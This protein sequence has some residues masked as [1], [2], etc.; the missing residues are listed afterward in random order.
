MWVGWPNGGPSTLTSNRRAGNLS[1]C[2]FLRP[3]SVMPTMRSDMQ[4]TVTVAHY[5][6]RWGQGDHI[7]V[8]DAFSVVIAG[9]LTEQCGGTTI[10]AGPGQSVVKPGQAVHRT[11]FDRE[12]IVL[13]LEAPGLFPKEGESVRWRWLACRRMAAG[14]LAAVGLARAGAAG[15][16]IDRL[17]ELVPDADPE[18][19]DGLPPAWLRQAHEEL[20][21]RAHEGVTVAEVATRAGVHPVHLSR[22]YRRHYGMPPSEALQRFRLGRA[23]R[24][25]TVASAPLA[26]AAASGGFSD[27]SHLSRVCRRYLGLTPGAATA[28]AT[29]TPIGVASV[30]SPRLHRLYP[31]SATV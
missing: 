26:V 8:T 12:S 21:D 23:L 22:S 25:A 10:S 3:V 19:T 27:Q 14:L 1:T 15:E 30:L 17:R 6:A 16:V 24:A 29:A 5:P 11:R 7:D 9:R 31:P 2:N 28:S 20:A 13:R 18:A 4:L